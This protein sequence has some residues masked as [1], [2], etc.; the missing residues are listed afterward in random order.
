MIRRSRQNPLLAGLW[1]EMDQ[2]LGNIVQEAI[3]QLSFRD[4]VQFEDH[5]DRLAYETSYFDRRKRLAVCACAALNDP[6]PEVISTL[7]EVM[8]EICNEYSWCLPAHLAYE[9]DGAQPRQEIDLFAAETAHAMAEISVWLEDV[10]HP[11]LVRQMRR[12]ARSRVLEPL[13]S[14]STR[15]HWESADHNWSAVCAGSAGMTALLLIHEPEPLSALIERVISALE[16][17][18]RGYGEDGGC[19]EGITYWT[20]GFGYYVYFAEMLADFTEGRLDLLTS[21]KVRRIASF[22]QTIHLSENTYVN[23]SDAAESV[24]LHSGMLSRLT[25]RCGAS[26]SLLRPPSLHEDHCYRWAHITRNLLWSS[27]RQGGPDESA[28]RQQ[29]NQVYYLPDLQWLTAKKQERGAVLA[30]SAKGGHN[31]EPHNHNDVGH[32][33]LH[34]N[35]ENVLADLG[36]GMYTKAYFGEA[37]YEILNNASRGHSVPLINGMEQQEGSRFRANVMRLDEDEKTALLL[38]DLSN[39]Y[40]DESLQSFT[41][42]FEWS[43]VASFSGKPLLRIEDT[44]QWARP[45]IVTEALISRC[46]PEFEAGRVVWTGSRGIVTMQYN[47]VDLSYSLYEESYS[48]HAGIVQTAY[49]VHLRLSSPRKEARITMEFH[50]EPLDDVRDERFHRSI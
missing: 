42:S 31:G 21:D 15:Y 14:R 20:Y 16:C 41:R 1:Q 8:W 23:Y 4:F 27:P 48:D 37:R 47:P 10:L 43:K 38:L 17:F 49:L 26:L 18:L 3:P 30:F 7:Q 25:D 33:I 19:A 22:P 44:V 24:V 6:R 29:E 40:A 39:A 11:G 12:E 45:G 28:K 36:A 2:E 32:F 35:G 34:V 5:G 9:G 13:L 46:K 50:A